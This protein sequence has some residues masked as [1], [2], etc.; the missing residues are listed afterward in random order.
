M[1]R[2]KL[3]SAGDAGDQD[4][5]DHDGAVEGEDLVVGLEGGLGEGH[6]GAVKEETAGD[7][8]LGADQQGQDPP[9]R[10][11][12]RTLTRYMTPMRL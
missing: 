11:A 8:E 7:E 6:G 9:R 2:T 5:E 1:G 3:P 10:K 4:Q 12:V